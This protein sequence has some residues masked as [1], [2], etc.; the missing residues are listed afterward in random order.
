MADNVN[1]TPGSGDVVGAE[2]ISSVKYQLVKLVDATASSITRTGVAANPLQVSLANTAAN[3]TAVKVDG[4]AVTQPVSLTST[5]VTGNV[6]VVQPTG[7]NL[8]TV[9][10]S[11][12]LTSITN[13]LPAGSNL[14]GKVG[15]DQ[16]T[17]GTTNLVALA[18]NQTVNVAQ[19]N[20]VTPLMGNGGTGT[21]SPRVTLVSDGTA[22]STAGF[23]SVKTDQTT[24][25]TTDLVAADI[26]KIA[27][28]N[29]VNGGLAGSQSIGGTVANNVAPT[30][31]P[32]PLAGIAVSSEPSANTATRISQ[33]LTDLV[34]KLIVLPYANPENF[35]SGVISTAMTGTTSTMC[36]VA[37]GASV[38]NY[39][40]QIT[41]S[42]GHA[43]Q[44]TDML[45]QD[46][47]SG[48]TLYVIPA[49]AAFGGATLTFPTPLRQ[50]TT[51]TGIYVA[52]VTTGSSTKA[53]IT[54][55]KGV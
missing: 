16:T 34:G 23:I 1:I 33:L 15:I 50:P 14:L 8:H 32:V 39:I 43:T 20:G 12:V 10:D 48:T 52:N 7:T 53:S 42:C 3:G 6:T 55:Y 41:V 4:S 45:I 17:P 26:T 13:A 30:G 40:T 11:G 31:N 36:V 44:G 49:A 9:L 29:I 25:G 5:T 35:I 22:I 24:H 28:T 38:R 19:V 37:P 54:G 46:G 18:A 21:G 51:N 47:S 2:S 27:G